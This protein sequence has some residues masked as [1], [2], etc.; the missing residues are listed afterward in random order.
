M[1]YYV[2]Y[3]MWL[4]FAALLEPEFGARPDI[5]KLF[6]SFS[7][8]VSL[9]FIGLRYEVGADWDAYLCFHS[10]AGSVT[11]LEALE[12]TD[13]GYMFFSWVFA[14]LDLGIWSLNLLCAS[15]IVFGL[16]SLAQLTARPNLYFLSAAPYLL[17]VVGMGYT[18][19][20]AS[21]GL[22]CL[23]MASLF[24]ERRRS[25]RIFAF[26]SLAFHKSAALGIVPI[27]FSLAKSPLMR[28][29]AGL[30]SALFLYYFITNSA[31]DVAM[32]GYIETEFES[33]G[34]YIR[35][36]Q[37]F[38]SGVFFLLF[39]RKNESDVERKVYMNQA[40]IAVA[41]LPALIV[42]PSSTLIDR[43]SLYA[44]PL[45]TYVLCRV[46]S[47]FSSYNL[48]YLATL[49]VVFLNVSIFLVW[50]NYA[51]H[52]HSWINYNNYLFGGAGFGLGATACLL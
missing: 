27:L 29:S 1:Y 51:E 13:P 9:I 37:I 23:A 43:L 3:V 20:S 47:M 46:P 12:V 30:L 15:T 40:L 38:L 45:Q 35:V 6:L 34:A 7:L 14:S 2:A 11:L 31:L 48:V 18:R 44:L 24:S 16:G 25:A 52:A 19:Q 5:K 17:I 49:I 28:S 50:I 10:L 26:T 39:L 22:V 4:C 42:S 8:G 32:T 36:Y 21:I 33:G 41:L